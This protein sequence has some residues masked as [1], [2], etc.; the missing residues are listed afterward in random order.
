VSGC[1]H[2]SHYAA[3]SERELAADIVLA[4]QAML[5]RQGVIG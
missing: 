4:S 5:H 1:A 2:E 3:R